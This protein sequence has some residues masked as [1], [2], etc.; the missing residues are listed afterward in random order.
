MDIIEQ[1]IEQ[2]DSE[3]MLRRALERIIQL[4]TDKSHFIY[5]LLQNAEDAGATVVK[6]VQFDDRLEV[7][8]NGKPFT[9]VN[10]QGLCDI[11][12]SDKGENLNQIGEFGV[13]FKSVFGICEVVK[14]YSAPGHYKGNDCP[15]TEPFAVEIVDFTHPKKINQIEL[16]SEYTTKFVLPYCAGKTF[17]GFKT[18][19]DL[20]DTVAKRLKDLG[21][22]TLLF[23]K[24]LTE[25][26]YEIKIDANTVSGTYI[27]ES[28]DLSNTCKYVSAIGESK[29][30]NGQTQGEEIVSY[31][32][33]SKLIDNNSSR[34]VDIAFPVVKK[35]NG[36]YE[37]IK[38]KSPFVSVYFPTETESKV[39]FIVQGPYRTT[40]NRSSIPADDIDNIRLAQKTTELLRESLAEL[41]RL[42]IL[43]MSFIRC[44]PLDKS[45]FFSYKLFE[46]L[47]TTVVKMLVEEEYLPCKSSGYVS[48]KKARLARREDIAELFSDKLLSE[49]INDNTSY[50]WLPTNITENNKEYNYDKL[51][52][53]LTT[54]LKVEVVR[55]ESL[56]LLFN[57][58]KEFL[59]QRNNDWLTG[60]YNLLTSIP[61]EFSKGG[62]GLNYL[63]CEIIKT[64]SGEFVAPYKK[65]D[66]KSF[67]PNVF[68]PVDKDDALNVNFIDMSL[69]QRCRKF[70]DE[71]VCIQKPNEYQFFIEYIK[72]AY[73][74]PA[75]LD[76]EKHIKDIKLFIKYKNHPEYSDEMKEIM[77]NYLVLRCKT[78]NGTKLINPYLMSV[79]IPK[80]D[81]G[82]DIEA[83]LSNLSSMVYFVDA[84]FYSLHSVAIQQLYE[85]AV[86]PTILT[87]NNTYTYGNN[88]WE[89][90]SLIYIKD[91]LKYISTHPKAPDAIIKS[92]II[93]RIL[94]KNEAQL[95]DTGYL[96]GYSEKPSKVALIVRYLTGDMYF[97][98]NGKWL[99]TDTNELVSQKA[100][101]KRALST[102]I[103]GKLLRDSKLYELLFFKEGEL[104]EQEKAEKEYDA[105]PQDK[106]DLYFEIELR[107]RYG[108]T[109]RDIHTYVFPQSPDE[110]DTFEQTYEFPI[111]KVKNW[112]TL[113]KHA[114]EM[115][116]WAAPVKYEKIVKSIRTSKHAEETRGYLQNMYRYDN[117]YKFACQMCH[118]A[119]GDIKAT[120]LFN[121]PELELDPM[122]LCLCPNC[123]ARYVHI[124][125]D[126][127]L[128]KELETELFHLSESYITENSQVKIHIKDFELWFTQT[129]AAEIHELLVLSKTVRDCDKT[130]TQHSEPVEDQEAVDLYESCIKSKYEA[131]IGKKV[132]YKTKDGYKVVIETVIIKSANNKLITLEFLTGSRAGKVVDVSVPL[133]EANNLIEE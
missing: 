68:L 87:G 103:Y 126:E 57:R 104:D 96:E 114:T 56:R 112:V 119:V 20:R 51:Y 59:T 29:K 124:R 33:F 6:F 78:A 133:V 127:A 125:N 55:P 101:T 14:L 113:K 27:L 100:I 35:D 53:Y 41:K 76:L 45:V 108:I 25:I 105:I 115:F 121:K 107:R 80:S 1:V 9:V 2:Q 39:D 66:A 98:W 130:V 12:K 18:D 118:D 97:D 111:V 123:A 116:A 95:A 83:Y 62:A 23:M 28:K 128:A 129:H 117:A 70:F 43:N 54:E 72:K 24:H 74:N 4:Y 64:S 5:E 82:T 77:R 30:A 109:P 93:F 8:H 10:L 65:T 79:Y 21:I 32:K 47:Y 7:L 52:K 50:Y 89:Q 110:E 13:G 44:L 22:T 26:S 38:S 132:K 16:P 37:C 42:K 131:L 106:R 99:F 17:S 48:A 84:E 85:L 58:N 61:A 49:L 69:Y 88:I 3:G 63:S 67:M 81:D 15:D 73:S 46:P 120:Q 122:N 92:Q 91:V 19:S 34:T 40:P 71:V 102:S 75:T 86:I 60:L 11:G 94:Q 36:D 31:L 90:F